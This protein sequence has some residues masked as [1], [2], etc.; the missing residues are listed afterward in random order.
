MIVVGDTHGCFL[1][2]EALLKKLPD[3][4]IFLVGD[5][6]D[7]GP[8]SRQITEFLIAHPEIKS[9]LGNHEYMATMALEED[10][11]KFNFYYQIWVK[12]GGD[13]TVNSYFGTNDNICEIAEEHL[14][15]WKSLPTHIEKDGLFVS[16]S[17]ILNSLEY[18]TSE[19]ENSDSVLWARNAVTKKIN[20]C[21][22]VFGHTPI[23]KPMIRKHWA[24]ID[25]GCVFKLKN[26]GVLT[27]LQ[28]P[29]MKIFQQENID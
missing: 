12:S 18:A 22:H 6:I 24:N 26:H 28:Y 1:T 23:P 3:D 20:N 14:N 9:V 7:R 8:R 29:T 25:T 10:P 17:I 5:T 16:H 19:L 4:E 11:T 2:F 15:F 13:T 21:F 27:A